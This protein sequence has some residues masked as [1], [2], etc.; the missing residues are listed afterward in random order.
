MKLDLFSEATA[1][2]DITGK[3]IRG[4]I[5]VTICQ[6]LRF[7]VQIL[8]TMYLARK[9]SP[10]DF[11]LLAMVSA[12]SGFLYLFNDLGLSMAT[13]QRDSIT[14]PQVSNLFW[15]NVLVGL[16]MML[17]VQLASPLIA[18]FYDRPELIQIT[19]WLAVGFL[20]AGLTAQHQ[21]LL[22]RNMRFFQL[23]TM[24]LFSACCGAVVAVI[25]AARGWGYWALVGQQLVFSAVNMITVWIMTAWLP[26]WP[27]RRNQT[28]AMLSFGGYITGFNVINFFARNMDRILI[29]R[30]VG[31]APLGLYVKAYDLMTLPLRQINS[32]ISNVAI[33]A[34]S[35]LQHDHAAYGR[36]YYNTM[37]LLA[38][39][40]G[41]LIVTL[42]AFSHEVIT[43]VLG[44]QW[45]ASVPIFSILAFAALFQPVAN[46]CG[47]VFVS[48]GQTRRMLQWG[49]IS[50]VCICLAFAAGIPWGIMG[51]AVSYAVSI[52]VLRIFGF[53]YAFKHTP[54]R[55]WALCV[56]VW[57]PY[58]YSMSIYLVVRGF[59]GMLPQFK[60]YETVALSLVVILLWTGLCLCCWEE[61]RKE[62]MEHIRRIRLHVFKKGNVGT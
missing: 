51:V 60:M 16:G 49:I 3:S 47:W 20:L 15:V 34:L 57:R 12:L 39:V 36:Y 52:N 31:A 55:F 10:G 54:L 11:G 6:A 45:E 62:V 42:A 4:G 48:S 14:P 8:M 7:L 29:G 5:W 43:L 17:C 19:L 1:Q 30:F 27:S 33:P 28:L 46:A 22:R 50:S 26:Q 44:S 24:D 21:A 53:L 32:P 40:T 37:N 35:R 58:V 9:L 61:F 25:M 38:Y 23:A 18:L 13:V 41:P 59:K 2:Q 56:R